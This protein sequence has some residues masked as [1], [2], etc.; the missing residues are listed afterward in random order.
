[1]TYANPETSPKRFLPLWMWGAVAIEIIVPSFF[2]IA[3][4]FDPGIWGEVQLGAFGEL[5]II[6]NLTMAFGVAVAAFWL[7]SHVALI[8]TIAAR[9]ATDLVDIASGFM[10]GPDAQTMTVLLVFTVVLLVIPGIALRW[11]I[12]RRRA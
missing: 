2:A 6:R 5:Y 11:L 8:A 3:T 1:M 4:L 9:F 12:A 7:R 10:R